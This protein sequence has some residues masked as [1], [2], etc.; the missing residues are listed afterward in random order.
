MKT[1]LAW[2]AA[3]PSTATVAVVQD[4]TAPSQPD[5]ELFA[6]E[7]TFAK[8][9]GPGELRL[10]IEE[11]EYVSVDYTDHVGRLAYEPGRLIYAEIFPLG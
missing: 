11:H 2:S 6:A 1:D 3:A 5:L 8:A 7:I 10:L 9:P 4:G